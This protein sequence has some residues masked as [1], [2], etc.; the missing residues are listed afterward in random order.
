MEGKLR[1]SL[2]EYLSDARL[3]NKR[4]LK[5]EEEA[6]GKINQAGYRVVYSDVRNFA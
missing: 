1:G 4:V 3:S 5:S 6:N 2:T